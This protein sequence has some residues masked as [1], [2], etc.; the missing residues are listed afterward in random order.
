MRPRARLARIVLLE[1][2]PEDA[3]RC[4]TPRA[5]VC[6]YECKNMRLSLEELGVIFCY[7]F[8]TDRPHTYTS[9]TVL[10]VIKG[11]AEFLLSSRYYP[12][13]GLRR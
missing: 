3:R 9:R 1:E 2:R 10:V 7:L 8:A 5:A 11:R 13:T 12:N 6:K 4:R